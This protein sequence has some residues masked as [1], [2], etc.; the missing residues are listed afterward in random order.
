MEDGWAYIGRLWTNGEPYLAVDSGIR[1]RW[2]GFSQDEYFDRIVAL[3]PEETG[4]LIGDQ[5]AA[6]VG[7]DGVVRD[8]SWMEVFDSS[9]GTIAIV[10]A[11][12]EDYPHTLGAALRYAEDPAHPCT[13]ITIH[14]GELAIFSAA[15]DGT[16]EHSM[17]LLPARAGDAPTEHGKPSREPDTGLL[18][19][20]RSTTYRVTA[21]SYTEL[22]DSSCFARWLLTPMQSDT[23]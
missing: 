18:V 22:D 23:H 1:H 17:T 10:Q 6:V 7:A 12:G 19:T 14:S 21:R 2:Q 8:D 3:G 9:D 4:V 16:G 11:S 5:M 20:A 13:L 15:C